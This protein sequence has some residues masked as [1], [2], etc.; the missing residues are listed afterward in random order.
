[1]VRF[2]KNLFSKILITRNQI[3]NYTLAASFQL[4]DIRSWTYYSTNYMQ[5]CKCEYIIFL[6]Y[7][8]I[9]WEPLSFTNLLR[10][11][12]TINDLKKKILIFYYIIC[13]SNKWTS[14][15]MMSVK[16]IFRKC[17]CFR[18]YYIRSILLTYKC[19]C[20]FFVKEKNIHYYIIVT[21][22]SQKKRSVWRGI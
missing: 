21:A 1:V 16:D 4:V 2:Y 9:N 3:S 13:L 14:M 20:T 10:R 12:H 5:I 7:Q 17:L 11:D 19:K 18:Q 8:S 15:R 6:V 22:A